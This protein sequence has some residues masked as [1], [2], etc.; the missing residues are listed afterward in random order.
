[1]SKREKS[2]IVEIAGRKWRIE[3]FDALTGSYIAYKVM[4]NSLPG[5][6]DSQVT[7]GNAPE[8]KLM[9]KQEFM[10]IQMDC[11]RVCYEILPA[12]GAPVIGENGSWGVTN[13]ETDTMTVLMLTIHALI[14]NISGFF[15]GNALKDLAESFKGMILFNAPTST[16]GPTPQ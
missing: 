3:K 12:G 14:F 1:M 10:E 7:G 8:R 11:L 2:K 9:S 15:D 16:N 4:G 13:I 6:I 5:A